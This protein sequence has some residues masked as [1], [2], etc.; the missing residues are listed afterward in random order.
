MKYIQGWD[1]TL[2]VSKVPEPGTV[3]GIGIEEENMQKQIEEKK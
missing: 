1:C 3:F 2:V